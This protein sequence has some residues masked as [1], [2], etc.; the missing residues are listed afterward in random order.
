MPSGAAEGLAADIVGAVADRAGAQRAIGLADALDQAQHHADDVLGDRL[1]V[2]AR[3]VDDQDA[4][5]GA[6]PHVDGV[7]TGAIG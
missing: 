6:H 4:A 1:G 2:A 3:L 7:V 5:L